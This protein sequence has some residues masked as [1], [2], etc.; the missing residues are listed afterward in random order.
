ISENMIVKR[1][2]K[3]IIE[4]CNTC[5]H[6]HGS[7]CD[8]SGCIAYDKYIPKI[9]MDQSKL[10]KKMMKFDSEKLRYDLVP[11][12]PIDGLALV[13]TYGAGK[14]APHNWKKGN[15]PED[16]ERINAALMR[17]YSKYRQNEYYDPESGMPHLYHAL[18]NLV[19]LIW[20]EDN[21]RGKTT[22]FNKIR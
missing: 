17:H 22:T 10:P 19:F 7:K 21:I 11:F 5:D 6:L 13:L 14:Y 12:G 4:D 3:K 20:H 16:I 2:P 9:E 18:C 1:D 15:T 8:I